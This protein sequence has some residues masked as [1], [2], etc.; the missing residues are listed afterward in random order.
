MSSRSW[1][2]A[3]MARSWTLR[4]LLGV[5]VVCGGSCGGG[6]GGDDGGGD[7]GT[8]PSP[9]LFSGLYQHSLF[10]GNSAPPPSATGLWGDLT[11][12]GAGE[13]TQYRRINTNQNTFGPDTIEPHD[14]AIEMGRRVTWTQ[15][16]TLPTQYAE[17]LISAAGD[18]LVMCRTGVA[19]SAGFSVLIGEGGSFTET[20]LDGDYHFCAITRASLIGQVSGLWGTYTFNGDG[21][22]TAGGSINSEGAIIATGA[23]ISGTTGIAPQGK[24]SITP[25]GNAVTAGR[26]HASRNLIAAAGCTPPGFDPTM[27][28]FVRYGSGMNASS[29]SGTFTICGIELNIDT[30]TWTSIVGSLNADGTGLW[31]ASV[32]GNEEG[33]PVP[34]ESANGSYAVADNGRLVLTT[35]EGDTFTG[36]CS[37]DGRFAILGGGSS[38]D[39]N[40]SLYFLLK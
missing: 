14:Y 34:A 40:P 20:D 30:D 8:L 32:A 10:G 3:D 24:M 11:A 12:D 21:T 27:Q 4:L 35:S 36:G 22:F 19:T 28:L 2:E 33:T 26:I 17:G 25:N 5:L 6:G 31:T 13:F 16:D 18:L 29:F 39:S 1:K 15:G 7:G 9:T 23:T 38:S 37:P